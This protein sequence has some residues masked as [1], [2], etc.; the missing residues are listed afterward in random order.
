MSGPEYNIKQLTVAINRLSRPTPQSDALDQ[1][2]EHDTFKA[3]WRQWLDEYLT[4]GFYDRKTIVDDAETA[5]QRLSNGRMI[6]WLNEAA[7][8]DARIVHAAIIAMRGR[9]SKQTEA[10]YAR[11]VLPWDGLAK[12]LFDQKGVAGRAT[13]V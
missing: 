5:Y 2:A 4:P 13:G 3:Q 7:G 11:L 8:E 6:V 10:M 1:P 9:D 12:L